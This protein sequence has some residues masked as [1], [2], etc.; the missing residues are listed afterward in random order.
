MLGVTDSKV[1]CYYDHITFF[2]TAVCNVTVPNSL[3]T[4]E[5]RLYC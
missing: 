3:I 4:S 1:M 5:L 2:N